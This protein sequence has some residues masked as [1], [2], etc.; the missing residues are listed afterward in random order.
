MKANS[1]N[2]IHELRSEPNYTVQVNQIIFKSKQ[3]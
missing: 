3:F 1:E 2:H